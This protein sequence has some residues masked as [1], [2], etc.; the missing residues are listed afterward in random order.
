M[1]L[2]YSTPL[3]LG[4]VYDHGGQVQ[5]VLHTDHGAAGDGSTDDTAAFQSAIDDAQTAGGGWVFVPPT[6]NGYRLN[7]GITFPDDTDD[8]PVWLIG[9]DTKILHGGTGVLMDINNGTSVT[10]PR[11]LIKGFHIKKISGQENTGTAIQVRNSVNQVVR[12]CHIKDFNKGVGIAAST[13]WCESNQFSKL[14]IRNCQYAIHMEAS[15]GQSSLATNVFYD[16][17]LGVGGGSTTAPAYGVYVTGST[18]NLYRCCFMPMTIFIANDQAVGFYCDGKIKGAFGEIFFENNNGAVSNC[19]GLEFGANA[20]VMQP[21]FRVNWSGTI[22]TKY[23]FHASNTQVFL[24]VYDNQF[25]SAQQ[26]EYMVSRPSTFATLGGYADTDNSTYRVKWSRN[27]SDV[28]Q[29]R[30]N[31]GDVFA[32]LD[33]TSG[34]LLPTRI[35]DVGRAV[36]LSGLETTYAVDDVTAIRFNNGSATSVTDF[37]SGTHMQRLHL[38]F[39]NGNTTIVHGASTIILNGSSNFAGTTNATLTLMRDGTSAVWRE[40][41]RMVP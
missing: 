10:G 41:G 37:T 23:K 28:M 4:P 15:G 6:A 7:S 35:M 5:N 11:H 40:I 1:A 3:D 24:G 12:D 25:G 18:T 33:D 14:R 26:G 9:S 34:K 16:C 22:G 39:L 21:H 20:T 2:I 31:S 17:I 27:A 19:V 29:L 36:N 38:M 32:M 30:V 13:A 8:T